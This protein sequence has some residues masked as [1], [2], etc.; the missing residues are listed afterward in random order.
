MIMAHFS[1]IPNSIQ[2]S[3]SSEEFLEVKNL[4]KAYPKADGS[5]F[6]VLDGVDLKIGAKEYISVIGHSGCGK[7]TLLKM[8]AGLEQP[9]SGQVLLEGKLIRKP[10][11][12]RMMVF[13]HY[14]LL[15]WLTVRD[16]IRLAV[17]EV[18]KNA[19]RAEK[20]RIVNE[21]LSMVHLTAAADKYP[22]EISGGMKQRVGIARALATRPKMLL[23][24]EPFGALDALTKRKLQQEVLKIWESQRQAVMMITH[25]VDEAIFMSDRIVLMTNGPRAN[26][27]EILAVPFP[28]PRDRHA[29]RETTEYY[30]LRNHALDFL[31]RYFT[32]DE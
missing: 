31:E 5:D 17:D 19:S 1:S 21:H 20:T 23:M 30:D 32:A 15:P 18:L 13:Q 9:T 4:V 12:D 28:H 6:V 24:D 14:S 29:M 26:I 2:N 27:G 10:G 11:A 16:N 8:I 7:S 3:F 22:E 25:D